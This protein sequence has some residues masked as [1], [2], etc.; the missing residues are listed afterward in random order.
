MVEAEKEK[1]MYIMKKLPAMGTG[2]EESFGTFKEALAAIE[3][4]SPDL[5]IVFWQRGNWSDP[6]MIWWRDSRHPEGVHVPVKK[7]S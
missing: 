4:M 5:Y 1:E 2:S 6:E 3:P 7:V